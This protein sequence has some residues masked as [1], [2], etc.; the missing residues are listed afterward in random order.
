VCRRSNPLCNNQS[1][2]QSV[3][4]SIQS[5]NLNNESIYQLI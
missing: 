3:S 5:N 1:I 2:N 4:Q